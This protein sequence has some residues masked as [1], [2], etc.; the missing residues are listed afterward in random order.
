[1][2]NCLLESILN[3]DKFETLTKMILAL[4]NLLLFNLDCNPNENL[5]YFRPQT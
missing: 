4:S 1:M 2:T 5:S 3:Y